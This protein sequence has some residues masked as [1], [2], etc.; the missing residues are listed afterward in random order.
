MRGS[1]RLVCCLAVGVVAV[2]VVLWGLPDSGGRRSAQAESPAPWALAADAPLF[3]AGRD[4]GPRPKHG[5][6]GLATDR[7]VAGGVV[8]ALPD[9]AFVAYD[10]GASRWVRVDAQGRMAPL[11]GARHLP[12]P[13][14]VVDVAAAP[15]GSLVA[16]GFDDGRIVRRAPDGG[17]TTVLDVKRGK[18][19]S[20]TDL[21]V[22]PDGAILVADGS[23][24]R[25]VLVRDG[26]VSVVAGTGA[27]G[28]SDR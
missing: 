18:S 7:E 2:S 5:D 16:G 4:W 15:D 21:T 19:V 1:S 23:A 28:R 27:D 10:Y 17:V 25:V 22:R 11:T 26:V 20:A 6:R 13:G 3:T 24:N 14:A 8:L 9:G 12:S